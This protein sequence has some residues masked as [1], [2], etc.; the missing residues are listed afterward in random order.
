MDTSAFDQYQPT[1]QWPEDVS[2]PSESHAEASEQP[3]PFRRR[4]PTASAS[5]QN[6]SKKPRTRHYGPRTCRI[7]L[8]TVL[9]TNNSPSVNLPSVLS[10]S[11]SVTYVSP[12]PDGRLISPCKCKGSSKYV[13][14]GCLQSWRHADPRYGRRNY[15]Q[16]PTCGF[17]YRLERMR[18]SRWISNSCKFPCHLLGRFAEYVTTRADSIALRHE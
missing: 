11:P 18:W 4:A 12:A 5:S 14:E 6:A 13:H 15:W 17:R 7:C 10:P 3:P 9:P 16:C 2:E 1:W 8:D